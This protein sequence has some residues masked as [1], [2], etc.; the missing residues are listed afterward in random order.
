MHLVF[1]E[2]DK[3]DA[4]FIESM[5]NAGVI[6]DVA[7]AVWK[8]GYVIPKL[9][10]QKIHVYETSGIYFSYFVKTYVMFELFSQKQY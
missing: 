7:I 3:F 4:H 9:V 10:L 6:N 1:G 8:N 5:P 2:G